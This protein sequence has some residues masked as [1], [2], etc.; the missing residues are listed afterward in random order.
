MKQKAKGTYQIRNWSDYNKLLIQRG[1]ITLWFSEDSIQ[2]WHDTAR[3]LQKGGSW[4]E[5]GA[6][7]L[8][9]KKIE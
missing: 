1:S 9:N 4:E 3:T 8:R 6:G 7:I 2:K 5:L